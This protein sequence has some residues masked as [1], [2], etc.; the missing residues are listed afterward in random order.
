[1]ARLSLFILFFV[2]VIASCKKDDVLDK[3]IVEI[4]EYLADNNLTAE[5]TESGLH[6]IVT[7]EGDGNFPTINDKV[8]VNYKGYLTNKSVFDQ[9]QNA[10]FFL[11]QVIKGWQEGIPKFSRGGRGVLFIPSSL[12]Y[13]STGAGSIPGDAVLIFEVD[14]ID[15]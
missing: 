12:G 4:K 15:F 9:S 1:M 14:L 5:S 11:Y 2:T 10:E 8:K 7:Q 13:G 6:Y 3:N